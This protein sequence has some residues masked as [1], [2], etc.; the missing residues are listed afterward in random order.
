MERDLVKIKNI[1]SESNM[2]PIKLIA[3]AIITRILHVS[4]MT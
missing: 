1:K 4:L 2:A 3:R